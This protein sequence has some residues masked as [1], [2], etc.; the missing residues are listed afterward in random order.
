LNQAPPKYKFRVLP[1]PDL[2]GNNM[3]KLKE[4]CSEISSASD[5]VGL[6]HYVSIVWNYTEATERS[7]MD[8]GNGSTTYCCILFQPPLAYVNQPKK[9]LLL[10]KDHSCKWM[11]T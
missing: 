5:V 10:A 7:P 11:A 1:L 9:D 8:G 4:F 3:V 6:S 2:L